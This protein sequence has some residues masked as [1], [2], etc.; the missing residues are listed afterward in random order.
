MAN[1]SF[2]YQKSHIPPTSYNW[3]VLYIISMIDNI[4]SPFILYKCDKKGED[5]HKFVEVS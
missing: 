3:H 2:V 1:Q 5:V 4:K